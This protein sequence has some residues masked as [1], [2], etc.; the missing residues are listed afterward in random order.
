MTGR[1]RGR[2]PSPRLNRAMVV[3]AAVELVRRDGLDSLTV[4]GLADRLDVRP[5]AVYHHLGGLDA[6][7]GAVCEAVLSTIAVPAAGTAWRTWLRDLA[8]K[9]RTVLL[10]HP[11][12]SGWFR[13]QGAYAERQL[14]I[15]NQAMDVLLG[16][17]FTAAEAA[18]G[19]SVL[20]AFTLDV[21]ELEDERRRAGPSPARQVWAERLARSGPVPLA[22]GLTSALTLF[23]AT[24][25]DDLFNHG[26]ALILDG[27]DRRRG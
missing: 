22:P 18:L 10:E 7:R 5:A 15:V 17:G 9:V 20:L 4:R 13:V 14:D 23:L 26:L 21:V 27:M 25:P 24:T 3:A 2:P 16:A 1:P 11:G 6:V 19:Y 8:T 12:T